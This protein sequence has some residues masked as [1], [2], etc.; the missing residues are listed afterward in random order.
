MSEKKTSIL[1]EL[2][3]AGDGSRKLTVGKWGFWFTLIVV[4]LY[5]ILASIIALA[6]SDM[7]LDSMVFI[8]AI[9]VVAI[10]VASF[11]HANAAEYKWSDKKKSTDK[12][13]E[14]L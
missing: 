14:D 10:V 7:T 6:E 3:L 13:K 1:R 2:I 12:T 11:N 4:L 5:V 9:G 8:A